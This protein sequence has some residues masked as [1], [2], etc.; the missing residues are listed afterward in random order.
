MRAVKS[1]GRPP[2]P[3]VWPII[4]AGMVKGDR[5]VVKG[6]EESRALRA[7]LAGLKVKY[8]RKMVLPPVMQ[9]KRGEAVKLSDGQYVVTQIGPVPLLAIC[10]ACAGASCATCTRGRVVGKRGPEQCECSHSRYI[11]LVGPGRSGY[12]DTGGSGLGGGIEQIEPFSQAD[13]EHAAKV[14]EPSAGF[15]AFT[16]AA[17]AAA[18]AA[19]KGA[20]ARL[21]IGPVP[22]MTATEMELRAE[23]ER[24]AWVRRQM[25]MEEERMRGVRS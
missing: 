23:A 6:A 5:V 25:Q 10:G 21:V 3:D 12:L 8:G 1:K 11:P 22:P 24:R 2:L 9:R 13:F 20:G 7:A 4:A 17:E 14:L 18:V 16:A 15:G 19:I